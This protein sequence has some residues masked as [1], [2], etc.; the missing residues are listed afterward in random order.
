MFIIG[1]YYRMKNNIIYRVI[2]QIILNNRTYY[3]KFTFV[4]D[5]AQ[6]LV[7]FF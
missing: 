6:Y 5:D 1:C 3:I 4:F 2:F 7:Q